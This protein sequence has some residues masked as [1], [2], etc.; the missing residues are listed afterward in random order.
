MQL[1]TAIFADALPER[2]AATEADEAAADF[3]A[4]ADWFRL[5]SQHGFESSPPL[6]VYE[7]RRATEPPAY[8]PLVAA[9]AHQLQS[10][11]N[12]YSIRFAPPYPNSLAPVGIESITRAVCDE[13]PR[14]AV[15]ELRCL[16]AT[17]QATWDLVA[18]F[19]RVGWS[20]FVDHQTW[21]WI[22]DIGT[23]SFADFLRQRPGALRSTLKRKARRTARSHHVEF[24]LFDNTDGLTQAI[25]DYQEVYDKCWKLPERH[26]R[27]V[28]ELIRFCARSGVL[29]LGLLYLDAKPIAAQL[30]ILSSGT[31]YIYKLAHD[32]RFDEISAGTLLSAHMFERAIDVDRAATIDFGV[33]DEAYKR[34]W[35]DTRRQLVSL[36]ACNP[37]SAKGTLLAARLRLRD[38]L[39]RRGLRSYTPV[40]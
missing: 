3:F 7:S 18:G 2:F 21:N 4:T 36:R 39:R 9:G 26:P 23:Q 12:Q 20:V 24:R 14:W 19:E 40:A 38:F 30:W 17:S 13:R 27:F 22:A 29:R 6:R 16:D 8:L 37:K 5:L 34:D 10:L 28:P 35:M 32:R 15:L 25:A 33:G 11:T 1:G 31:A